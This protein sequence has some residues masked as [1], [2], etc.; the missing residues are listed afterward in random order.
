MKRGPFTF[1]TRQFVSQTP[2]PSH[3]RIVL[4]ALSLLATQAPPIHDSKVLRSI[5]A[6]RCVGAPATGSQ[7]RT[8]RSELYR[9]RISSKYRR[10]GRVSPPSMLP[11]D[12]C[13]RY[14][15]VDHQGNRVHSDCDGS[16]S[17]LG[18]G[19]LARG[20]G[21]GFCRVGAK[22]KARAY[23]LSRL[24]VFGWKFGLRILTHS[25]FRDVIEASEFR[26]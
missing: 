16:A 6:G 19:R 5:T 12:R 11:H 15:F 10:H 7:E 25:R 26:W 24:R 23:R 14:A 8:R 20:D 22:G 21:H 17:K 9:V 2:K 13:D 3:Q 18:A 4:H 1:A